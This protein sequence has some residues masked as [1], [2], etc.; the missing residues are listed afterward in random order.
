MGGEVRYEIIVLMS[1]GSPQIEEDGMKCC[2]WLRS[3]RLPLWRVSGL[4]WEKAEVLSFRI[5]SSLRHCV[6]HRLLYAVHTES[7]GWRIPTRGP[8]T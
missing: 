2:D 4:K 3:V 6:G 8:V 1:C 7:A 5:F